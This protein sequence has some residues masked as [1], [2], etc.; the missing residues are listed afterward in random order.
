[1]A[2]GSVWVK[3]GITDTANILTGLLFL[4]LTCSSSV[5]KTAP[6]NGSLL[7][8]VE[9]FTATCVMVALRPLVKK[10]L[11]ELGLASQYPSLPKLSFLGSVPDTHSIRLAFVISKKLD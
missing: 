2:S 7:V 1:M 10:L 8:W 6:K 4:S 5:P 3:V 9:N 11:V